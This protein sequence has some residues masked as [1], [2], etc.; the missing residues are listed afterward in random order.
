MTIKIERNNTNNIPLNKNI[1]I[2]QFINKS[3]Q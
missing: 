1:Y 3:I 2:N